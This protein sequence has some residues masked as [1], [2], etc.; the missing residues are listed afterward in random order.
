MG[1]AIRDIDTD[2]AVVTDGFGVEESRLRVSVSVPT[3]GV[4]RSVGPNG[5]ID[6]VPNDTARIGGLCVS[7]RT[8]SAR[9]QSN[10]RSRPEKK[11]LVRSRR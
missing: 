9:R 5:T 7:E 8:P 1:H 6:P 11:L 2:A 10:A 4:D 3:N